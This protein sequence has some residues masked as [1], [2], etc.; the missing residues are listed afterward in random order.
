[1]KI[2]P[3]QSAQRNETISTGDRPE[4]PLLVQYR[5]CA[6]DDSLAWVTFAICGIVSI[7]LCLSQLENDVRRVHRENTGRI[8]SGHLADKTVRVIEFSR[9]M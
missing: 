4:S 3:F 8:D 2:I 1:M 7:V 9:T 5:N 6:K